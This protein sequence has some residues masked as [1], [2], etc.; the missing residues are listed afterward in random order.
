[1][2]EKLLLVIPSLHNEEETL[3]SE[4]FKCVYRYSGFIILSYIVL[5]PT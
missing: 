2:K 4:E 1:M 5:Q 3:S